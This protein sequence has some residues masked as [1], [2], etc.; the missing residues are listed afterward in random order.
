MMLRG[1]LE[2]ENVLENSD[3]RDALLSS[4]D[5]RLL[6]VLEKMLI[7]EMRFRLE[8]R[9]ANRSRSRF[10]KILS[11]F[12]NDLQSKDKKAIDCLETYSS[13]MASFDHKKYSE[14]H[15]SIKKI[16][17]DRFSPTDQE[18][19]NVIL[20]ENADDNDSVRGSVYSSVSRL[21]VYS[22]QTSHEHKLEDPILTVLYERL[23]VAFEEKKQDLEE[24]IERNNEA[25]N[26]IKNIFDKN[27]P[28]HGLVFFEERERINE[29]LWLQAHYPS[30]LETNGMDWEDNDVPVP[31]VPFQTWNE[32]IINGIKDLYGC[33]RTLESK[34]LLPNIRR[35]NVGGPKIF[36][37]QPSEYCTVEKILK[38]TEA[39]TALDNKT[40]EATLCRINRL[41]CKRYISKQDG[42]KKCNDMLVIFKTALNKCF[43]ID[44]A[45]LDI[46]GWENFENAV[47]DREKSSRKYQA[48]IEKAAAVN[49]ALII[50]DSNSLPK[51]LPE[52]QAFVYFILKKQNADLS[53]I[54]WTYQAG[55]RITTPGYD[56]FLNK[57]STLEAQPALYFVVLMFSIALMS[58]YSENKISSYNFLR[59][60]LKQALKNNYKMQRSDIIM[61]TELDVAQLAWFLSYLPETIDNVTNEDAF[62]W[63]LEKVKTDLLGDNGLFVEL[64]EP[65]LEV[66]NEQKDSH[67][68]G[69]HDSRNDSDTDKSGSIPSIYESPSRGKI[70]VVRR[71]L[72]QSNMFSSPSRKK[73]NMAR[74]NL[75]ESKEYFSEQ[76]ESYAAL[77]IGKGIL[78]VKAS[79]N[80]NDAG[81]QNIITTVE[82]YYDKYR[83]ITNGPTLML[84]V[85]MNWF[86]NSIKE[87]RSQDFV[88]EC[89]DFCSKITAKLDEEEKGHNEYIIF[90]WAEW[91][92][93][94]VTPTKKIIKLTEDKNK[95]WDSAKRLLDIAKDFYF[96]GKVFLYSMASDYSMLNSQLNDNQQVTLVKKT[97]PE[98]SVRE[99]IGQATS[100]NTAGV[101]YNFNRNSSTHFVAPPSSPVQAVIPLTAKEKDVAATAAAKLQVV[102][103]ISYNTKIEEMNELVIKLRT[104]YQLNGY[105]EEGIFNA[106]VVYC[107]LEYF[108]GHRKRT[109]GDEQYMRK[110]T[111]VIRKLENFLKNPTQLSEDLTIENSG[112]NSMKML[113]NFNNMI[114]EVFP[115]MRVDAVA[116]YQASYKK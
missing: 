48:L 37:T 68:G 55:L 75:L 17:N 30:L 59:H 103:G 5:A 46:D 9:I 28:Q 90:D 116:H 89:N 23:L 11:D 92:G 104:G 56:D 65:V 114:R 22:T 50:V 2:G 32:K 12:N 4:L 52:I 86:V 78:G 1:R 85:L 112:S 16:I 31:P 98:V 87:K 72:L 38:V 102:F 10:S 64:E 53:H 69:S 70:N 3:L 54:T 84:L 20:D 63:N 39:K 83:L 21:S 106:A 100:P 74:H 99:V 95:S 108:I 79:N 94:A 88:N 61:V 82:K 14:F 81:E 42:K 41:P 77:V 13:K 66:T 107:S 49:Q 6:E 109:S 115:D 26:E 67:S 96:D 35:S 29:I 47:E 7:E 71:S 15:H 25:E 101:Q 76:A 34:D 43:D 113:D 111:K 19:I 27:F 8:C 51:T 44:S 110:I 80:F 45:F 33:K 58:L 40:V 105:Q 24:L 93:C 36:S 97:S 57:I 91:Q 62:G 73:A 18:N 60:Q